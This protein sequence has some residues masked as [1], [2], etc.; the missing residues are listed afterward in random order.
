MALLDRGLG[1]AHGV[2]DYE[3]DYDEVMEIMQG[4]VSHSEGVIV[5]ALHGV[6]FEV[7]NIGERYHGLNLIIYFFVEAQN[8]P[9]IRTTVHKQIIEKLVEEKVPFHRDS[10]K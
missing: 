2:D 6:K 4:T 5:N 1:A 7:T 10:P 9:W 8:E 3:A